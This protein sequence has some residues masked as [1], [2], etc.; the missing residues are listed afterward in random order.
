MYNNNNNKCLVNNNQA[1]PYKKSHFFS[2]QN[3]TQR[4]LKYLSSSISTVELDSWTI[5]K[6]LLQR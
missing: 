5:E 4:I 1:P 2:S 3:I 6:C